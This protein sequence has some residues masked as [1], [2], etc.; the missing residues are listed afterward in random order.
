NNDGR[1][2]RMAI[3]VPDALAKYIAVKG[4]V[5]VDGVSLTVNGVSATAFEVNIIPHTM[6]KTILQ[7]YQVNSRV[8]IEVDVVAR[9]LERLLTVDPTLIKRTETLTTTFLAEHGF[10]K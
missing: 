9:Y 4:S 7:H 8:N 3:T 6:S 1:S 10:I 2:V 5:C